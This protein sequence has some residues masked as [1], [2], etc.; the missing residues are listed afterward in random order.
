MISNYPSGRIE[1]AREPASTCWA[2]CLVVCCTRHVYL[3]VSPASHMLTPRVMF[4]TGRPRTFPPR[5]RALK[6]DGLFVSN[7]RVLLLSKQQLCL[8]MLLLTF[9]A[10]TSVSPVSAFRLN[11]PMTVQ[12]PPQAAMSP[13][14][15]NMTTIGRG[16]ETS[17]AVN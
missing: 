16:G 14:S 4:S 10:S 13:L 6:F 5:S 8:G 1:T 17:V 9:L 12:T 3:R 7:R 2:E 15:V 11:E